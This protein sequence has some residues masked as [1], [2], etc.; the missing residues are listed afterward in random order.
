MALS[1]AAVTDELTRSGSGRAPWSYGTER[2]RGAQHFVWPR[3]G[4]HDIFTSP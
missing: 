1:Q 2:K 4:G 3:I